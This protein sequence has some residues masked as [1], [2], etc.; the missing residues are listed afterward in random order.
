MFEQFNNINIY[1][2]DL[3]QYCQASACM[4]FVV[5]A[6]YNGKTY[7]SKD[8]HVTH[9][10]CDWINNKWVIVRGEELIKIKGLIEIEKAIEKNTIEN[11]LEF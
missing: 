6:N 1:S 10:S 7:V 3:N 11:E 9:A 5:F 2:F 8:I 4:H